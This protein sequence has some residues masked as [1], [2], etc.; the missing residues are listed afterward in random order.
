MK[1]KPKGGGVSQIWGSEPDLAIEKGT[2]FAKLDERLL[3]F[4]TE[5]ESPPPSICIQHFEGI[6]SKLQKAS[7]T[8]RPRRT[9]PDLRD[10]ATEELRR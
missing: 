6:D 10:E 7:T 5:N 4:I 8:D 3:L 2:E 9:H 1:L